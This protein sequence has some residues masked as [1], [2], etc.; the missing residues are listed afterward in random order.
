MWSNFFIE[1]SPSEKLIV[2]AL[3][4]NVATLEITSLNYG[5][6]RTSNN[7]PIAFVVRICSTRSKS[8]CQNSPLYREVVGLY[9]L[10]ANRSFVVVNA[11]LDNTK[12]FDKLP[13]F[14]GGQL[15]AHLTRYDGGKSTERGHQVMTFEAWKHSER[16]STLYLVLEHSVFKIFLVLT[17]ITA[18]HHWCTWALGDWSNSHG[19]MA[20]SYEKVFFM[21]TN[22]G[23]RCL[24]PCGPDQTSIDGDFHCGTRNKN[25]SVPLCRESRTLAYN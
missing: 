2:N 23:A 18:C 1:Y 14:K 22:E 8:D 6:F 15:Y 16:Q 20:V 25:C 21:T 12:L 24:E 7:L 10:F 4:R 3:S 11:L 17:H 13:S 9:S 5:N 19:K